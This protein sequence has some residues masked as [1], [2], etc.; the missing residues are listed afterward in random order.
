LQEIAK[1][2][3]KSEYEKFKDELEEVEQIETFPKQQ[4][5]Q[6]TFI[7]KIFGLPE[8]HPPNNDEINKYLDNTHVPPTYSNMDP[9][10]W[11]RNNEKNFPILFRVARKYLGI[12]ATSVPSKR[13]FSDAGN[14]ITVERNRLK[15]DTVNELLFLKRNMEYINPFT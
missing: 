8:P 10:Q 5:D 9:F 11:W 3:L 2:L 7:S 1:S 12:P 6:N 15:A 14:Q 4:S 13:L